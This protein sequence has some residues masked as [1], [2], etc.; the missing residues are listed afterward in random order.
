MERKDREIFVSWLLNQDGT[1]N[2]EV[3][4]LIKN[5][6]FPVLMHELEEF[7]SGCDIGKILG[8]F[9]RKYIIIIQKKIILVYCT[10]AISITFDSLLP[11]KVIFCKLEDV[12]GMLQ[13]ESSYCW[14]CRK[15]LFLYDLRQH[16]IKFF[17]KHVYE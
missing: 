17:N 7:V 9:N 16:Q 5:T 12:G 10:K 15:P 3:F 6:R 14:C 11:N 8:H 1:I 13:D 4:S 2:P